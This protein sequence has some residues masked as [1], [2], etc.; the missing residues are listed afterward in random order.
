ML[1]LPGTVTILI[2]YFIVAGKTGGQGDPWRCLGLLL[3]GIGAVVLLRCVWD[4]WAT[5]RGTLAP[6]DPPKHLVVRGLYRVVRNPMYVAVFWILL[7]QSLFFKSLWLFYYAIAAGI[8]IHLF[9][10]FYEEPALRRKFGAEYDAY[11]RRVYRW[12]PRFFEAPTVSE[13]P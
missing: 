12:L 7:G 5:G 9:V 2:P 8:V 1:L 13:M 11:C 3:V 6:I 4:F 10:M